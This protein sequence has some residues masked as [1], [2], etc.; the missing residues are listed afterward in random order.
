MAHS[1]IERYQERRDFDI[2]PEPTG[3]EDFSTNDRPI[4]VIQK[5]EYTKEQYFFRLESHG[6]LKSWCIPEGI[7]MNPNEEQFARRIEDYPLSYSEFEGK[8]P[9]EAYNAGTIAIINQG[10]YENIKAPSR[11]TI[12]KDMKEDKVQVWLDGDE[13]KGGFELKKFNLGE[14]KWLF[15]KLKDK[16]AQK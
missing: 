5:H 16:H 6:V 3:E 4:F 2:T 10:E 14:E 15:K 11:K 8:I 12:Q 9:K 7:T 13:I 1:A